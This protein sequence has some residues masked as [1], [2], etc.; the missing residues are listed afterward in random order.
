MC[1]RR[2]LF[3][4]LLLWLGVPTWTEEE[5]QADGQGQSAKETE[6]GAAEGNSS[7]SQ[8]VEATDARTSDRTDLDQDGSDPESHSQSAGPGSSP[9]EGVAS[10]KE[11]R[12]IV[13]FIPE[14]SPK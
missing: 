8:G 9:P 12:E 10:K 13:R 1:R 6:G 3:L 7:Q 4:F 5:E 2:C 14:L 11:D